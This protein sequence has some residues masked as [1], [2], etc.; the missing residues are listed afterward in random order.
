[1]KARGGRGFFCGERR[2]MLALLGDAVCCLLT[3][4]ARFESL[5]AETRDWLAG[6]GSSPVSFEDACEA[7]GF[8]PD[9]MRAGI[10]NLVASGTDP[11]LR[12]HRI[13]RSR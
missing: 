11:A 13:G 2:L 12:V 5:R 1:M 10:E 7:L 9:A 6:R 4:G 3:V 8:N